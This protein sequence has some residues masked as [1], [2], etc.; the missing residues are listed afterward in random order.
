[1][2]KLFFTSN[3]KFSNKILQLCRYQGFKTLYQKETESY[4]ILSFFKKTIQ[5]KNYFEDGDTLIIGIGSI[6]YNGSSKIEALKNILTDF[7][8]SEDIKNIKRNILGNF[9][10]LI[11]KNDKVYIFND[12]SHSIPIY[13]YVNDKNIIIGND[14]YDIS[15]N[16]AHYESI[17]LNEENF[18]EGIFQNAILGSRTMFNEIKKLLGHEFIEINTENK[19]LKINQLNFE[20]KFE[21]NTGPREKQVKEYSNLIF[22]RVTQIVKHFKK[23]GIFMTGGLDSRVKLAAFLKADLKPT[24]FYGVG[25]SPITNTKTEDYNIVKQIANRYDLQLVT[26]NWKSPVPIDKYWDEMSDNYGFFTDIYSGTKNAITEI[27]K[28]GDIDFI[29]FGYMGESI[30]NNKWI[31]NL[32][33]NTINIS[34]LVDIYSNK[35]NRGIIKNHKNIKKNI[36][37]EFKKFTTKLQIN[38]KSITKDEYQTFDNEYRK[39]ADTELLNII[40]R[41]LYSISIAGQMEVI[42]YM[43]KIPYQHKNNNSFPVDVIKYLFPDLLNLPIL[44]HGKPMYLAD[45][46]NSKNITEKK[47]GLKKPII[48]FIKKNKLLLKLSLRIKLLLFPLFD[49]EKHNTQLRTNYIKK[50]LSKKYSK[51]NGKG[52]KSIAYA[53][54]PY[55]ARYYLMRTIVDKILNQDTK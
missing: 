38:Q 20:V 19:T 14:L 35:N 41:Y 51:Y 34:Q 15:K 1:M 2:A 54:A 49:K 10:I 45:S 24:L 8:T 11:K 39:L 42:S 52:I 25:N 4:N 36:A 27:E 29:E 18:L 16:I 48:N 33:I 22:N 9:S 3:K 5:E 55:I 43:G 46:E 30:R 40:N 44:T 6:I 23:I 53:S 37:K 17:T 32:N 26:M 50:Y 7:K 21:L 31:D 13:Y 12:A 28:I 47:S